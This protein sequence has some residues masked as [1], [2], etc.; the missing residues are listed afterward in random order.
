MYTSGAYKYVQVE[1]EVE[2]EVEIRV[3]LRVRFALVYRV[4]LT[5]SDARL[6]YVRCTSIT[7]VLAERRY[8]TRTR[9]YNLSADV[10]S[11]PALTARA[12]H[13]SSLVE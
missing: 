10:A 1:L 9:A 4:R 13:R 7:A 12:G 11:P 2:V 3:W 8:S 6:Y 5:I